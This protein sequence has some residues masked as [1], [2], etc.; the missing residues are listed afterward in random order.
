[1]DFAT[2]PLYDFTTAPFKVLTIGGSDSGGAAGVQAD[3]KT[4]TALGVYGMSALTAVTA[5]N[6]LT[7]TA[8]HFLPPDFIT[9]QIETV[10][11][12][13]GATA[14]KTGFMGQEAIIA[15]VVD[16]L[17]HF[18]IPHILID[19]VLV[20]YKGK[21]MFPAAVLAAYRSYLLPLAT[22]LTPNWREL[23]LLADV[24]VVSLRSVR[25]LETAVKKL[26]DR[27]AKRILVTGWHDGDK[28]VDWFADG[29]GEIRPLSM[30]FIKTENRHGSGDTLSAAICA[31]LVKGDPMLNAIQKAQKVTATALQNARDWHLGQGHG[32]LSHF[33]LLTP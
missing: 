30:P 21:S 24:D 9:Q 18:E 14:V 4:W 28:I 20:N 31:F 8:V 26:H 11:T 33:D 23:A 17:T 10:L 7:V 3:L 25:G 13:Y 22:L 32:P 16:S 2:L 27:G 6:S 12:D 29:S 1:M 5:Q 15:A 19:P